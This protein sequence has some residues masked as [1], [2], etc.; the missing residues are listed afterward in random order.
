MFKTLSISPYN[1]PKLVLD[2][3]TGLV[4]Y[5]LDFVPET[6]SFCAKTEKIP[7]TE[8][9]WHGQYQ[10]YWAGA[11]LGVQMKALASARFK[12]EFSHR[13]SGKCTLTSR[14]CTPPSGHPSSRVMLFAPRGPDVPL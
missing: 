1:N 11:H 8:P 10:T 6:E 4:L 13:Y 3:A 2:P 5:L 9:C 14:P 7:N 12:S